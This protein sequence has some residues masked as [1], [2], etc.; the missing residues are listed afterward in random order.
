VALP[1]LL[2]VA[3]A[4]SA[5][6]DA[7]TAA[8]AARPRLVVLVTIDQFRADYLDRFGP[9]LRGGLARLMRGGAWF[10]DAHHDHAITETAPGHATL[11]AGRFPRSTGITMNSVGV[12][13]DA[14]PLIAGGY[15]PGASPRRFIGSTLVD[16]LR[17]KDARSRA[18]SV[19]V[20]DRGAILSIGRSRSQVYWYSP[21]GRFVTSR[22]YA[23]TLPAWVTAFND[24]HLP[25]RYADRRWTLLLPDSAYRERD[26]VVAEAGGGEIAFPHP[27][28]V[29]SLEAASLVRA[30]PFIDEVVVAFALHGMQALALGTGPETDVLA[31]SLSS[32]DYVGHR[33]GPDSRE[34]HDQVL[35]VDRTVGVLLDS[36]YRL[37]DSSRVL[38]VLTSDHG[39]GTIPE[40]AAASTTPGATRVDL[41]GLLPAMRA[42]L[43]AANVDTLAMDLDQQLVLL[44]RGAFRNAP[45][46]ADSIV[47][48]FAAAARAVPG[49]RRVDRFRALLV[50][51]LRDPIA[52]RW[53]HQLPAEAQVELVVTLDSLSTWGGNVASHGSSY[54]HDSHVPVIFYGAGV[55]PGRYAD[56]VR[57]VDIAPT[58]AALVGVRPGERLDGVVLPQALRSPS[59]PSLA[60]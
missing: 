21:D 52:R 15:G 44:D 34:M 57:T 47:A 48:W 46:Q 23:D 30:T 28:P 3:G 56:F 50:D 58:L 13:D 55:H 14:S 8:S 1:L 45:G 19:S 29:D 9:Q 18:L 12:G 40:V 42:R 35:R 36:I 16:W 33:F 31:L 17:A 51:S 6:G 43:R 11:L 5:Q 53:S 32:T 39:V 22:Y 59:R 26:S 49:V 24:R 41:S 27:L 10:T 4:L 20:K 37:R 7:S 25:Q 2:S 54:N 60:R 38:V